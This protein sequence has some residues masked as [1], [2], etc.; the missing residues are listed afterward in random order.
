VDTGHFSGS[1]IAL[2]DVVERLGHKVNHIHVKEAAA[3]GVPTFVAFG[4]GV[5]DNNR[6][7][8]QMIARGYT[9]FISVEL[10]IEDKSNLLGDLKVPYDLFHPYERA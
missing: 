8:E 7:I 5:T 4:K 1:N 2:D 3:L 9:G 6:L 10:A